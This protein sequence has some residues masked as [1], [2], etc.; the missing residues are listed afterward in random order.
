MGKAKLTSPNKHQLLGILAL[1]DFEVFLQLW[2]IIVSHHHFRI[3]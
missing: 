3:G 1:K 2:D